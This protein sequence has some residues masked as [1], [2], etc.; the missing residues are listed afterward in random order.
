MSMRS[1]PPLA[2]VAASAL[3]LAGACG[4]SSRPPGATVSN[5]RESMRLSA[6]SYCWGGLCVDG[7]LAPDRA[8]A[9]ALPR[10]AQLHVRSGGFG[11]ASSVSSSARPVGVPGAPGQ[12]RQLD[13]ERH[14]G[15]VTITTA[16]PA[17]RYEVYV[18]FNRSGGG[19]AAYGFLVDVK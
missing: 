14:G 17:G 3:V 5:G 16:L 4:G 7:V 13:I 6:V 15:S 1:L 11:G 18:G 9:I 19:D 2:A 10:G 12:Y 8:T